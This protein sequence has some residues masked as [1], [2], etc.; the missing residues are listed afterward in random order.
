MCPTAPYDVDL[1]LGQTFICRGPFLGAPNRCSLVD[2][3]TVRRP[4]GDG[5]EL[6]TASVLFRDAIG[7][8]GC[9]ACARTNAAT[10]D[11]RAGCTKRQIDPG[12]FRHLGAPVPWI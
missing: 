12:F 1:S 11:G 5:H 8:F 10:H 2:P 9:G 6:A 4:K 3:E 7:S